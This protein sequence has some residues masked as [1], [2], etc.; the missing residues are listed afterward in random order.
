MH[1]NDKAIHQKPRACTHFTIII[2]ACY[3]SIVLGL[4]YIQ[5]GYLNCDFIAYITIA[6]RILDGIG[7]HISGIW[8]PLFSWLM[9]PL[10]SIGIDDLIAG[11]TVLVASGALYVYA[12]LRLMRK[13]CGRNYQFTCLSYVIF[14]ACIILQGSIWSTFLLD[15]DIIASALF[16]LYMSIVVDPISIKTNRSAITAG[17]VGGFAYLAK[18]YMLPFIAV[19]VVAAISMHFYAESDRSRFDVKNAFAWFRTGAIVLGF[20]LLVGGPW[21][22][23]LSAHYGK[24]VFSTAGTQNH[25]NLGPEQFGKD[26]LFDPGLTPDY[27]VDPHIATS[28]SPLDGWPEFYHQGKLLFRNVLNGLGH[29]ATWLMFLAGGVM[30]HR[31]SKPGQHQEDTDLD[32]GRI[33]QWCIIST[34]LYC[35]GYCLIDTQ[36]RF[37]VPVVSPLLC[38]SG[39]VLSERCVAGRE[40]MPGRTMPRDRFFVACMVLLA[41]VASSQDFYRIHRMATRHSQ[42]AKLKPY[43][44]IAHRLAEARLLPAPFAASQYHQGLTLAYAGKCS[45][46]YYGAPLATESDELTAELDRTPVTVYLRFLNPQPAG[47]RNVSRTDAP[48]GWKLAASFHEA[49][50]GEFAIEAYTRQPPLR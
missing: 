23:A 12:L 9:I 35:S 50:S 46:G 2:I 31:V 39:L 15:P 10:I 49:S 47:Q 4:S 40:F 6:H 19:H 1:W 5:Y 18:A 43:I 8:S 32:S 27:I 25:A 36:A 21:I 22:A 30:L 11:R 37:V 29:V 24:L 3:F 13:L 17:I 44:R 14:G 28:W 34:I 42:S 41:L 7:P 33:L 38:L 20:M 48:C 26:P 45:A 16:F